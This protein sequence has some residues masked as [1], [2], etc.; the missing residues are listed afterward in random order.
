[1]NINQIIIE[2]LKVLLSWPT[3]T[4]FLVI[5]FLFK[6]SESIKIFLSNL[7]SFKAGLFELNQQ[8]SLP[9]RVEKKV[10]GKLENKKITLEKRA[11]LFEF[12]YLNLYLVYNTKQALLWFY[13]TPS[14]RE[15]YIFTF[16]LPPQAINQ[17]VEK[18]AIFNAL[19]AN[20][21]IWQEGIL[22]KIT[23]KGKQFLKFLGYNIN[24]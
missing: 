7:R 17:S 10:E 20:E 6:F 24:L 19:L 13:F 14:T 15:N 5:I 4:F 11:E 16:I 18:E 22:F 1:M 21:L 8:Q 2:Y 12:A 3:I 23:E 9:T